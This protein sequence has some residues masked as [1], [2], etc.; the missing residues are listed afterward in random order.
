MCSQVCF[1]M[2]WPAEGLVTVWT[3]MWLLSTMGEEV[4]LE[5]ASVREGTAA[6]ATLVLLL[7]SVNLEIELNEYKMISVKERNCKCCS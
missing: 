2:V 4:R 7:T 1:E 6:L 5:V 3:F